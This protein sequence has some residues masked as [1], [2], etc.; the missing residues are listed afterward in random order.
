MHPTETFGQWLK[1]IRIVCGMKQAAL[2]I[3]TGLSQSAISQLENDK[4]TPDEPTLEKLRKALTP[5]I[6]QLTQQ[7]LDHII[8]LLAQSKISNK[9]NPI[10]KPDNTPGKTKRTANNPGSIRVQKRLI[11]QLQQQVINLTPPSQK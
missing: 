7:E 2:A 5:G 10:L 11:D 9:K 4:F 3:E 6:Q 8:N 1:R